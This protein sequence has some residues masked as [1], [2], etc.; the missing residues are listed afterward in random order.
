MV[1]V[2]AEGI[3]G[4]DLATGAE[5]LRPGDPAWRGA[6]WVDLSRDGQSVAIALTNGSVAVWNIGQARK[7]RDFPRV[8]LP[9]AKLKLSP[10]A[11]VLAVATSSEL[12]FWDVG[13][14]AR[15]R[16][17]PTNHAGVSFS[18]D[19]RRVAIDSLSATALQL[20]ELPSGSVRL[21][22]TAHRIS[23]HCTAFSPDGRLLATGAH[24][25]IARILDFETG[26]E[27]QTL[28]GHISS[29]LTVAFSPDGRS[30]VTGASDGSVKIWNVA[31]G[32]EVLSL[33]GLS[34][35]VTRAYFSPDGNALA[36]GSDERQ[37]S[38]KLW[39]A[40]A[41]ETIQAALGAL[42]SGR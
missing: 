6:Q 8:S 11:R 30:L 9:V 41:L 20:F 10:D 29:V 16:A 15:L 3:R 14:G 34:V 4:L 42:P 13:A 37:D 32:Q 12:A 17:L 31:T 1:F 18:P 21:V 27:I 28:R 36:I 5:T 26:R 39:R 23:I 40:P 24:D 35:P 19:S 33:D 7:V 25:N 22:Q 38:L 2:G